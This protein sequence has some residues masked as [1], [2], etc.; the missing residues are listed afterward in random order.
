M[1]FEVR[2]TNHSRI[3]WVFRCKEIGCDRCKLRYLCFT[4][5]VIRVYNTKLVDSLDMYYMNCEHYPHYHHPY[6][7]RK[8]RK[9]FFKYM[10]V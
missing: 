2:R 4:N 10:G 7:Q 6:D 5:K 9:E 1:K 8:E 3:M